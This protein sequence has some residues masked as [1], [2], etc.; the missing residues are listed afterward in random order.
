MNITILNAL[1]SD[2]CRVLLESMGTSVTEEGTVTVPIGEDTV[3]VITGHDAC[4][5]QGV[6]FPGYPCA[7]IDQEGDK[8]LLA[9]P[10][11]WEEIKTW[12][13]SPIPARPKSTTMTVT[14]FLDRFTMSEKIRIE[15]AGE[16]NNDLGRAVRIAQRELFGVKDWLVDLTYE[17]M[18][19]YMHMLASADVI[20]NERMIEILTP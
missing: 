7:L 2:P 17:S 16:Q 12:A 20:T 14:K 19:Q 10:N 18:V 3:T 1:F 5:A 15:A 11:S 13:A 9:F 8:H 6:G 4:V